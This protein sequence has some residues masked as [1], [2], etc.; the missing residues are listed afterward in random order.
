MQPNSDSSQGS[1]ETQGLS[2][3]LIDLFPADTAQERCYCQGVEDQ[4]FYLALGA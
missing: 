4:S 2:L 1:F 3:S